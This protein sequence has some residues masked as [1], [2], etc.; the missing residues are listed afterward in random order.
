MGRVSV[1][2]CDIVDCDSGGMSDVVMVSRA[3]MP[4]RTV[5]LSRMVRHLPQLPVRIAVPGLQE[6]YSRPHDHHQ[7]DGYDP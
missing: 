4:S 6:K 7:E 2:D 1:L 5:M 3:L